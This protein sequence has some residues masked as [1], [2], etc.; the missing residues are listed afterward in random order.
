M[1]KRLF[2]VLV[3]L[4]LTAALAAPVFAQSAADSGKA[5]GP[6]DI[7]LWYGAAMTEAGP[8]PSDWVGYSVIKDKLNIN[9]KLTALPSSEAD[10]DVKISA[11][12]AGDNLPDLFMVNKAH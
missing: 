3:V 6:I 7:E 11:A 2:T 9:L 1:K 10:Q 5:S 12:S 4:L 8:P